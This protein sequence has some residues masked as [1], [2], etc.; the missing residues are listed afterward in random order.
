MLLLKTGDCAIT[1]FLLFILVTA[2]LSFCAEAF[3]NSIMDNSSSSKTITRPNW[4]QD[5]WENSNKTDNKQLPESSLK[6][7]ALLDFLFNSI[8]SMST[9]NPSSRVLPRF[10]FSPLPR[11]K[12]SYY[13]PV[14]IY[15]S[16]IAIH[17]KLF[18]CFREFN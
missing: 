15:I 14:R 6:P 3:T 10:L 2:L 16:L 11:D 5:W 1:V 4:N 18:I 17:Y 13:T 7:S 9:L 8:T 12:E